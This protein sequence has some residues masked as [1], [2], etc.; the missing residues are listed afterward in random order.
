MNGRP[1]DS[2]TGCD[3]LVMGEDGGLHRF[4]S[5][6]ALAGSRDDPALLGASWLGPELPAGLAAAGLPLQH[7]PAPLLGGGSEPAEAWFGKG[8]CRDS[9]AHGVHFR[10]DGQLLFG[11]ISL[12]EEA[13]DGAAAP[14]QVAGQRAYESLFRVLAEEGYSHL[15]RVWNYLDDINGT[16][17]GLE[18]YRQFNIGRHQA[19]SNADRLQGCTIP[20]ASALGVAGGPLSVA[21]LAARTP[22]IPLENPRQLSAYRYPADYGPRSPTFSRAALARVPGQEWLFVSGT[23]S[24]V[25]HLTVHRGDPAA[26]T[27]EII[28]NLEALLAEASRVSTGPAYRLDELSGRAYVRHPEHLTAVQAELV[29]A[30]GVDAPIV[31][32]Q[33]DVCRADLLVELEAQACHLFV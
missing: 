8:P 18:R 16:A 23:A 3:V 27:R 20:A 30:L 6:S 31:Y 28:A 10:C 1:Q 2:T 9:V 22:C 13:G 11:V 14:L 33:A 32:V 24:I 25:G 5:A 7:I 29:R 4:L 17:D 12:A 26:Q 19:F 21:F 15:W